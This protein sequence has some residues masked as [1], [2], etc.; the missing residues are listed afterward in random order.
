MPQTKASSLA[1]IDA[2][3]SLIPMG[4]PPN[5]ILSVPPIYNRKEK[6][7]FVASNK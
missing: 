4:R 3:K 2:H 7:I 1:K 6:A 5:G